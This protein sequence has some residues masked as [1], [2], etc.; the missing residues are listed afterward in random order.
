MT[1]HYNIFT[2]CT[3]H[4]R[5]RRGIIRL[6]TVVLLLHT[7]SAAAS[8]A[9]FRL[10]A[11]VSCESVLVQL[12]DVAEVIAETPEAKR[13]L[14]QVTLGLAPGAGKVR[15]LSLDD[16]KR[17]L[18]RRGVN[19][20][21][22]QFL[23]ANRVK[24][25]GPRTQRE[26]PARARQQA[27]PSSREQTRA[28]QN[29][30]SAVRS[31]LA[32]IGV[33]EAEALT[34]SVAIPPSLVTAVART[35]PKRL[36]VSGGKAP[37]V[38]RQRFFV[39]RTAENGPSATLPFTAELTLPHHIV[40]ARHRLP[41][42]VPLEQGDVELRRADTG[43]LQAN[44]YG[45]LEDVVGMQT[46]QAL[47]AGQIITSRHVQS[48]PLVRRGDVVTVWV[49][50]PG[51]VVK[52]L[53]RARGEGARG[54]SIAL[55]TLKDRKQFLAQVVGVR[56]L[57]VPWSGASSFQQAKSNARTASGKDRAAIR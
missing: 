56:E 42:G 17:Q 20:A 57:E 5:N 24:L 26:R 25:L 11:E 32:R 1:L 16:I 41:R 31:Y 39:Q 18:R 53:A 37:W 47:E 43:I 36:Q 19:L 51:F 4:L 13:S 52:R 21:E 34:I 44:S 3:M 48:I 54:D 30:Q 40:V 33:A 15:F 46:T 38:G 14:D 50:G 49:R 6:F 9:V 35:E 27:I 10:R 28:E 8:G 22:H 12:G 45:R 55:I 23:G 29:L 7:V 2:A